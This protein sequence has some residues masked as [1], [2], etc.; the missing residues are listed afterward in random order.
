[1]YQCLEQI[2]LAQNKKSNLSFTEK[3][4]EAVLKEVLIVSGDSSVDTDIVRGKK[5]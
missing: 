5:R 4:L 1:M 3:T 2:L